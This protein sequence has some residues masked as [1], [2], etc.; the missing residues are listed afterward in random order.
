M[1]NVKETASFQQRFF[2]NF[3]LKDDEKS[4]E[5]YREKKVELFRGIEG[6]VL[7]IGP[8]TGVNFPFFNQSVRWVGVEPNPAMHPHLRKKAAEAGIQVDL[9]EGMNDPLAHSESFS[10]V[11]STLVLCSVRPLAPMLQEIHRVLAPGGKFF[12]IEHVLDKRNLGR[13][14]VQK[15]MP[16]TPWR[17]FSDG[18]N[19]GIDIGRKI[20]EAGFK[21]VHY[22]PYMQEGEGI[23]ASINRPHI[24]GFAVK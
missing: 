5:V 12:F 9:I 10:F 14:I 1:E 19:P 4:H 22:S 15:T 16:F 13:A 7:E 3:M 11:I 23:V 18:C 6:R 8:G 24:F 2:A 21:R 17:Y 20:D